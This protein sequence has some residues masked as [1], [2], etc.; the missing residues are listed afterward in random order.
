MLPF[1]TA[2]SWIAVLK[3]WVAAFGMFLFARALGMRFGGALLAGVIFALN[4]KM[5]T[6]IIYPTMGSGR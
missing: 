6:W 4:L 2:L 1:W 5:V 3:L